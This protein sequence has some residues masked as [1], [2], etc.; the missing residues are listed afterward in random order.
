MF[1][2]TA[3]PQACHHG[4]APMVFG[5][6]GRLFIATLGDRFHH[7]ERAQALDSHL[8]RWCASGPM[9]RV[10]ADNPLVG[11]ADARRDLVLGHHCSVQGAACPRHRR[12]VDARARPAGRR[13]GGN[14]TSPGAWLAG[15]HLRPRIRHRP[16]RSAP[17][18]TRRRGGAGAAMDALDRALRD[19]LLHRRRLPAVEGNLFVGALSSSCSPAWF[20]MASAWCRGAPARGRGADPRR[21]PGA[22]R[23]PVAARRERRARAADRSAVSRARTGSTRPAG[24]TSPACFDRQHRLV[25]GSAQHGQLLF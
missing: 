10:P 13:R 22:G 8:G 11:R 15:D 7:R 19:G 3:P 21:S 14:H 25:A 9:A 1:A 20:S 16:P 4:L 17:A 6:D 24:F 23:P 18:A 2:R 12:A 5:R